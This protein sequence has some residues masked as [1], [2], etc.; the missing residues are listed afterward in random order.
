VS[1]AA[2]AAAAPSGP[3]RLSDLL[4]DGLALLITEGREAAAP[5]L[6]Q[7][8]RIFP[9]EELSVDKGLLWGGLAAAAAGT[10]WDFESMQAV[11]S[12]QTELARIA[13]AVAPLCFTLTGDA[14]LAAWRGDLAAASA[15]AAEVNGLADAIGIQQVPNGAGLLAALTGDEPHSSTVIGAAIDIAG[16]RGEGYAVQVGLWANAVL[17]NG[18]ARYEHALSF[19][20]QASEQTPELYLAAW[21]LPELIE[22]AVRTGNEVIA[23]AA[24]ERL[25]DSVRSSQSDWGQGILARSKALVSND[26]VAEE[27]YSEALARFG[28][29]A[30]RPELARAHLL[31]GEWLRRK[32]RRV[33]ARE[34]LSTAHQIFTEIG[35]FAFAERTRRELLATGATVRKRIAETTDELTVQE[36]QVA[37]LV[38]E[39]LSNPEIAARLYISP[40]TVQY[41]LHKVFAKLGIK[42]RNELHRVL[43]S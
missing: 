16:S 15:L 28:R 20:L 32:G 5:T 1:E 41:H 18:L 9:K 22:A 6:R 27:C 7:A 23:A 33:A 19:S 4:L 17:S 38:L 3:P 35:M 40:R 25:A 36:R 12:R 21:A 24:L 8:V 10:L 26:E 34:E 29:T 42:S 37:Q 39:G 14:F 30:L 31:Y 2:R 11:L 13:G 43:P